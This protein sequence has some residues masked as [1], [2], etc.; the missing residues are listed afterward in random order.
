[1]NDSPSPEK[2]ESAR[3]A[4]EEWYRNVYQGEK[5]QLTLRALLTGI[6]LG[7]ILSLSNLYVGFKTGWGLGVTIT[8][9]IMAFALYKA[10]RSTLPFLIKKDFT[11][12]ENNIVQTTASASA[13]ISSAGL[14]SAI[15][16]LAMV[17]G[18]TLPIWKLTLWILVICYLGLFVAVPIK[19]QMINVEKLKFPTGF[20][21]AEVL[22]SMHGEG[23]S[24]G[25]AVKKARALYTALGVGLIATWC[26]DGVIGYPLMKGAHILKN[27]GVWEWKR[28]LP[29]IPATFIPQSWAFFGMPLAR[30]TL[31]FEGSLILVG[32]GAIIGIRVGISLLIAALFSYGFLAPLLIRSGEIRH[33]PP[34]VVAAEGFTDSP[35]VYSQSDLYF[36]LDIRR[37][38]SLNLRLTPSEAAPELLNRRWD[39]AVRYED[40]DALLTDLNG[41]GNPFHGK[42][43]FVVDK[44]KNHL[45]ATL[46][47]NPE[48]ELDLRVGPPGEIQA[49][50][51]Q[52]GDGKGVLSFPLTIRGPTLLSFTAGEMTGPETEMVEERMAFTW[53]TPASYEDE[54]SLLAALNAEN[55]P[56]GSVNPLFG[57][58]SFEFLRGSIR[59]TGDAYTQWDSHLTVDDCTGAAALGFEAGQNNRQRYGGYR[60][61]VAWTMWPGVAMMVT[62]GL[63]SFFFQWRT[64]LRAF[65]GVALLFRRKEGRESR[66]DLS[67]AIEVPGSWFLQGFLLAGTAAVILQ[68]LFFGISWWMAI[69]AVIMSF[70]LAIVA[71]RATGETDITPVGPMGKITQLMYGALAP[72]NM[73]INLMTAN[74]TGGAAT[75]SADLLQA[76]KCGYVVGASPRKQFLAQIVGVFTGS[77]ICV[78]IYTILVPTVDVL[79]S[80]KLPAPAAQVWAGVARLL[81]RGFQSMP[82]SA[83]WALLVGALIGI[84]IPLLDKF[85]PKCKK[86]L[87]SPTG[88][89]I[90]MIIPAFNSISMF[91]GALIAWIIGKRKKAVGERYT[92]PVASGII[93]GE[94]LMGIA[95]AIAQNALR[96]IP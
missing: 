43:R 11:L 51:F 44:E 73:T 62:A 50:G 21:T 93:A 90:A 34:R 65:S 16:A 20:A 42:V 47:N 68:I 95:V 63:L 45:Y 17:S 72:G 2:A 18:I 59:A 12:L 88:M 77:L 70:F 61:I 38:E 78:P 24:G 28:L 46:W 8:A 40:E 10:M 23:E 37:G 79:G 81:S 67:E 94:S 30:L 80:D 29:A 74:V 56:D 39:T 57:K 55:L 54:S 22:K 27:W 19:R 69:I 41:S 58:V 76:M 14:V 25:D 64:V 66:T 85:F 6:F 1:M 82:T 96:W 33:R 7:G 92:V 3:A 15:P 87:P 84:A 26:R 60:S 35:I 71:C 89:G 48:R 75:A 52:G 91:I 53:V 31:S 36:P 9:A 5:P 86:F 32:A 4:E 83:R 49:L 13:F